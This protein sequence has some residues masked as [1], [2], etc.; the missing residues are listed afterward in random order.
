MLPEEFGMFSTF[1]TGGIIGAI[2]G[3]LLLAWQSE[4]RIT[5]IRKTVFY[6]FRD[7]TPLFYFKD[8]NAVKIKRGALSLSRT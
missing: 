7:K 2:G 5:A 1:G 3:P 6:V 8:V 4:N